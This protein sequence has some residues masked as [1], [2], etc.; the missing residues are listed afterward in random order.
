VVLEGL[1]DEVGLERAVHRVRVA[2]EP[3]FEL[4]GGLVLPVRASVG[5]VLAAPGEGWEELLER[6]D[7]EM[8]RVKHQIRGSVPEQ[9]G[10]EGVR[11]RT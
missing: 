1:T 7:L 4:E 2:M 8:Y 6:A 10:H 5:H 9:R 3:A 11:T